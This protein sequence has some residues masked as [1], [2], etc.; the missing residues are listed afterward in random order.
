[1][2]Y[3]IN[4]SSSSLKGRM[5]EM[6]G[7]SFYALLSLLTAIAV[8]KMNA[9]HA[10]LPHDIPEAPLYTE[11]HRYPMSIRMIILSYALREIDWLVEEIESGRHQALIQRIM[12]RRLSQSELETIKSWLVHIH[13]DFFVMGHRKNE[14]T[15]LVQVGRLVTRDKLYEPTTDKYKEEFVGDDI[16]EPRVFVVQGLA[17]PLSSLLE[18][19]C[20]F[21]KKYRPNMANMFPD[22][23][24]SLC[25]I[26]TTLLPYNGGL[27]YMSAITP[28]SVDCRHYQTPQD[29][30]NALK[31]AYKA[32]KEAFV[33]ADN[34]APL[35]RTLHPHRDRTI[36]RH[37]ADFRNQNVPLW[38][39]LRNEIEGTP[40]RARSAVQAP[41]S[42]S[43]GDTAM[44]ISQM[45][46]R[47]H[48]NMRHPR[49]QEWMYQVTR[50]DHETPRDPFVLEGSK[51]GVG[52][53]LLVNDNDPCPFHRRLGKTCKPFAKCCKTMYE[54]RMASAEKR[55]ATS[56][57]HL[58]QNP[59]DRIDYN[60]LSTLSDGRINIGQHLRVGFQDIGCLRIR[61]AMS[62][63]AHLKVR[64]DECP[65]F[66][67]VL[68]KKYIFWGCTV[69]NMQDI[70][71]MTF[72]DITLHSESGI[73]EAEVLTAGR[74]FAL[75]LELKTVIL[76]GISIVDASIDMQPAP[77][78]KPDPIML[79]KNRE[80]LQADLD[81]EVKVT[82]DKKVNSEFQIHCAYCG[83]DEEEE[84]VKLMR[85]PCKRVYYCSKDHQRHHWADHKRKC[86][87]AKKK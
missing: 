19:P 58:M 67:T 85:C 20:D 4:V 63:V 47:P 66:H 70:G 62:S 31:V 28:A 55:G 24:D 73:L 18:Q 27:T 9:E 76:D 42:S 29:Y 17:D 60:S 23:T 81:F 12:G 75:I 5:P 56:K 57:A 14:G 68:P 38:Q 35:Y 54:K 82:V 36:S 37:V 78:T 45:Y 26:R 34:S 79:E 39:E 13:D 30:E 22:I 86:P 11:I 2:C 83:L 16:H 59:V 25:M 71:V 61:V 8:P 32:Y 15:V 1:M 87:L 77:Y 52:Q 3:V 50:M 41:L 40:S 64:M 53:E 51:H 69:L 46:W 6:K 65:A 43:N 49:Y 84:G 74:L 72:G 7:R 44:I 10:K 21:F 80:L 33:E 48:Q